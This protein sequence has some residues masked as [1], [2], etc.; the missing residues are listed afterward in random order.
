M[1]RRATGRS[2]VRRAHRAARTV[3]MSSTP[4]RCPKSI[5]TSNCGH[6]VGAPACSARQT[7]HDSGRVAVRAFHR[8]Q[9]HPC[10]EPTRSL[11]RRVLAGVEVER[12]GGAPQREAVEVAG[13]G[14]RR[15]EPAC[16]MPVAIASASVA[17]NSSVSISCASASPD[18]YALSTI[19]AGTVSALSQQAVEVVAV[20]VGTPHGAAV[21][22]R[23]PIDV[24]SRRPATMSSQSTPASRRSRRPRAR[25]T[26]RCPVPIPQADVCRRCGGCSRT[27][28]LRSPSPVGRGRRSSGSSHRRA[29]SSTV[30]P[31][32]RS[33]SRTRQRD[34]E[35]EVGLADAGR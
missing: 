17:R 12:T 24:E 25:G 18:M 1:R 3:N 4:I 7:G 9:D 29:V 22:A 11:E 32:A 2:A 26:P 13:S 16:A 19:T 35:V 14:V 10:L 27:R 28:E 34:V 21:L 20:A 33:R 8:V 31:R 30:M 23:D 6:G 15:R 5:V